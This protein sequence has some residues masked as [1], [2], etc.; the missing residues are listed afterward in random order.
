[1]TT[2]LCPI[3]SERERRAFEWP[4]L[5]T[6]TE[7]ADKYRQ[8]PAKSPF[9]GKYDSSLTPYAR[10]PQDNFVDP[11]AKWIDIVAG[12]QMFKTTTE[13]NMLAYVI[14]QDPADTA[15]VVPRDDD[16]SYATQRTREMILLS[17]HTKKHITGRPL[18]LKGKTFHLDNM[19]IFFLISGSAASLAEKS[20]K[21][22][23]LR[24]PNKFPPFAGR[25][26]G[27]IELAEK[28]TI[29]YGD[30]KIVMS[31]TPELE[32][33]PA[34]RFFEKSNKNRLYLPCPHCGEYRRWRF[35]QLRL[36]KDL[37][38][39]DE[40]IKEKEVWYECEVCG[41]RIDEYLKSKIVAGYK[42]AP[43][44]H[45]VMPDKTLRYRCPNSKCGALYDPGRIEERH[46]KFCEKCEEKIVIKTK[47]ISGYQAS[48]LVSPFPGVGWP[49]IMAK[50]FEANTEMG[51]AAG[52]MMDFF[53]N[54]M[55]ETY[56]EFGKQIRAAD[57]RKLEGFFQ[58]QTVPED[59]VILIASADYHKPRGFVRIDYQIM[60]YAPDPAGP[61]R[62]KAYVIDTGSAPSWEDYDKRVLDIKF[63]WADGTPNEKTPWLAVSCS[64]EDAGWSPE[65]VYVH[66]RK[67][68]GVTIPIKG[69]QGPEL[70][71]LR[72]SDLDTATERRYRLKRSRLWYRG[73]QLM[74]IDTHFF[75]NMVTQWA[76]PSYDEDPRD[77]DKLVIKAP[78]QM[79]IYE[80]IPS[81]WATEFT[82]EKLVPSINKQGKDQF[83]W[84]PIYTGAATHALDLTVYN[85]AAAYYKGVQYAATAKTR[86]KRAFKKSEFLNDLPKLM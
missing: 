32:S 71:P 42:W 10:D 70:K 48:S 43:L 68:P 25:E 19:D 5:F 27:P 77:P 76:E 45:V 26:P 66:C 52:L 38:D 79:R 30:C 82:N 44:N 14:D 80:G 23:F 64:F 3:F 47:R 83:V 31:C 13:E 4:E 53:N 54:I 69:L 7:L 33:S 81:Y 16:I 28:R 11:E 18:D 36:P 61:G 34:D 59:V 86:P 55:G 35:E 6:P 62:L 85:A 40:I 21:Y 74:L 58:R 63:P 49:E 67:R 17:P 24:E 15:I 73:M 65:D 46:L 1:M 9:G 29:T 75:K 57:V 78:P 20:I 41:H 37:R 22:I 56:R 12:A 2:A 72:F 60:G 84:K 39:P 8:L 50:W 51:R